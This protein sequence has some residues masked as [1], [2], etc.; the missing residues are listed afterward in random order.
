[1]SLY[2]RMISQRRIWPQP[3]KHR[4]YRLALV[5]AW[6]YHL[7]ESDSA[8]RAMA[9]TGIYEL[10]LSNRMLTLAKNG[11]RLVDVGANV[12]YFSCLWMAA[13]ASNNV[14]AIE[15]SPSVFPLLQA[16]LVQQPGSGRIRV[17]EVAAGDQN[18]TAQFDLGP[19]GQTGWGGLVPSSRGNN[20]EVKVKRLDSFLSDEPIRVLKVDA[21]GA[22]A[23]VLEGAARLLGSG[24]VEHIFFERNRARMEALGI[25]WERPLGFLQNCGFRLEKLSSGT[26]CDEWHACWKRR[27]TQA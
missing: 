26:E 4:G 15:A 9:W 24:V 27:S 1:M 23:L 14:D 21:E 12:G 5:P 13:S 20:I 22:D 6:L 2:Y 17:W 16:N 11:G 18:G 3:D 25:E 19:A 10:G 8:H 7:V